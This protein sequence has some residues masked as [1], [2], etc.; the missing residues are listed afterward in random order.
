MKTRLNVMRILFYA[1]I[2]LA[3]ASAGYAQKKKVMV[4]EI[5][6]G[7]DPR[8]TRYVNLALK[9]AEETKADIV[10]IEMN[11]YGGIVTDAKDIV[12]RILAFK[13]PIWVFI[14]HNAGSA[15]SLISIGCDSIYMAPAANIGASTVVD[16]R[17]EKALD[18]YQSYMR[19][20]FRA[21]AEENHRNPQI[22]EGMVDENVKIEGIKE[23]GQVITL[24]TKE[25]VQYG[26]CEGQVESI[27]EILSLNKIDY[28]LE[29]FEL[30]AADSI[31]AFFI[32]PAISSLLILCI[33]AGIY[34]EMQAPGFGFPGLAAVVALILYMVP[35]YL[36]GLAENWE[37]IAFFVGIILIGAEIFVIPGFGVAGI[38]GIIITM[39]SL[40]LIM[41][42]N[43]AFDFQF[44][45]MN[46]IVVALAATFGGILGGTVLLFVGGPKMLD[47]K[48]FKR[49]ALTE[50]QDRARGYT[51]N[52]FPEP[53]QGK[54]GSAQTVLRPSGKVL[55]DGKIFDA[56]T[57]GEYIEAGEPIEVVDDEGTSLKVRKVVA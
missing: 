20:I 19:S 56:F 10:I 18:K 6:D 1:V 12:D 27:Q 46:D 38:S 35:Y 15:G 50:T 33:I 23:V 11:T 39:G 53:M 7:I 31:I 2:A 47:S 22:A 5:R 17:G 32:N 51:A 25:A 4:M 55:I 36:N 14:N 40:V 57:R 16:E 48:Y 44:V 3:T 37:I 24:T 43:D 34:F 52:F 45:Q 28:E 49:V 13:K 54:K 21:T 42:N 41:L 30:S 9:H 26:Y 8:M 29:R